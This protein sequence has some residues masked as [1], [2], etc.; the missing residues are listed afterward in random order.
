MEAEAA[1]SFFDEYIETFYRCVARGD[2]L[3][4]MLAFYYVPFSFSSDHGF[5]SLAKEDDVVMFVRRM[6]ERLR[7]AGYAVTETLHKE[8]VPLNAVSAQ[9]NYSF[10]RRRVDGRELERL[11]VSYLLAKVDA[12]V[13]IITFAATGE[14][15]MPEPAPVK[16]SR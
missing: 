11:T 10:L 7:T 3:E 4:A 14:Q 6:V 9:C 1:S 15:W 2:D 8:F 5:V 12:G 16:E 13:R